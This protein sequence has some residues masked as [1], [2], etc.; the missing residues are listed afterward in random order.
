MHQ[1]QK[2]L[3]SMLDKTASIKTMTQSGKGR[4]TPISKLG[5]Y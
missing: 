1:E 5:G 2:N 4:K 3:L